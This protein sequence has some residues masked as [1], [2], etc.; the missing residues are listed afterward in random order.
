MGIMIITDQGRQFTTAL[1]SYS[2]IGPQGH[3]DQRMTTEAEADD[4]LGQA[5]L[6]ITGDMAGAFLSMPVAPGSS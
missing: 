5:K 2:G 6:Y 4:M 1:N 3:I